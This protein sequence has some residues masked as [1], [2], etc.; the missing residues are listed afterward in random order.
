MDDLSVARAFLAH[1]EVADDEVGKGREHLHE[2]HEEIAHHVEFWE[3]V[4]SSGPDVLH[5]VPRP[6]E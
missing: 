1:E 5:R 2:G 3:G 4:L 6:V